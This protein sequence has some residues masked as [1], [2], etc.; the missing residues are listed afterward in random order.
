MRS[1]HIF[2]RH[3]KVNFLTKFLTMT[4][5]YKLN[6]QDKKNP[7]LESLLL[8]G[9]LPVILMFFSGTARAS[10]LVAHDFQIQLL[11]SESRITVKD[12][13]TVPDTLRGK[14]IQFILHGDL[15][16]SS[17]S[18]HLKTVALSEPFR[19]AAKDYEV[20][21]KQY[22]IKL[23]EGR[24]HFDLQYQGRIYHPIAQPGEEYER[25]MS[26][27]PGLISTDGVFLAKSTLWYPVMD[28]AFVR[29]S[30]KVT[31]PAKWSAV[32]Q[33]QRISQQLQQNQQQNQKNVITWQEKHPQDDIYLVANQYNEYSQAAGDVQAMVFLREPDAALAQK[34]LDA[35][36]QYITMYNRLIGEYPYRKFA[37]VE[38]FWDT[39]YG[40]PSFTLLGPKVIR[41]PFILH[42]SYPHEILH[43]WWG[44]GVYVDYQS[45]NWAEG[46]TAY[47]ADHLIKE[48]RGQ[49]AEYRRGALQKYTDFVTSERNF[50]LTEFRSRHNASTAAVG[51]GKTMMLFHMLRQQLGDGEFVR[52]LR[53][54][55]Q[56]QKF[57]LATF[58]DVQ[59]AF[60]QTTKQ[61][62]S[63]E[64]NQWV[65]R[66]GAPLLRIKSVNSKPVSGKYKI[67]LELEQQQPG[68][69]YK[70][71]VPIAVH[72]QG[73]SQAYQ[74]VLLMKD[75]QQAFQ[76]NVD[77]KPL[78][79]DVDPEFD[80]FRRLHIQEI[81]AALTQG[82][83]AEK[84]LILLPSAA[85]A[86]R[87][88]AY[89]QMAK[90]WQKSQEGQWQIKYDNEIDK[91]PNDS[92]IWLLGWE[93]KFRTALQNVLTKRGVAFAPG[94]ITINGE[95]FIR[96]KHSILLTARH[97][98]NEHQTLVWL[99][100][101][102]SAAVPGLTRKLPHYS[103]YSY[104]AF[105]GSE[106]T[107]IAKG[108]WDIRDSPMT[109][110]FA[111]DDKQLPEEITSSLAE[112]QALA[113]LPPVFSRER[114][115]KDIEFMASE[116]MAGRE[117]GSKELDTVAG[118]IAREFREAGLKPGGDKGE[119]YMQRWQH[120][121]GGKKGKLALKNIIGIIPGKD[122]AYAK[123]SVIISAHYDHLGKGWPDVHKG[124][125]GK[126]HHGA[127]D[128]ASGVAVMLELARQIAPQWEPK[129]AIV[130]IA[131]TGEEAQ[132]VGSKYYVK[133]AVR[134]PAK[135]AIGVINLD[136]VGRL[137][138]NPLTV[139]G[140]GSAR[141]WVH[142]FRG[143][144]FV[145][146][147]KINS[148]NNDFGFSD[149]K[150]FLEVGVPGVQL[151]GSVHQD[152]HRPSDTGDKIDADGLI[153]VATVLKEAVEY[154]ANR[155]EPMNVTIEGSTSN[156]QQKP[157]KPSPG[158]KVSLGTVPDFQYQGEGV[159]I[160]GTVDGS[161]AQ[162][163]GLQEGDI[164]T[165]IGNTAIGN[166]GDFARELRAMK[167][168][169]ETTVQ[170]TRDGKTKS[171][172]VI[173]EAR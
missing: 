102:N 50:P 140:V 80:V 153:K 137:G 19:S 32:S 8:L 168:G 118:Y 122:P 70:L 73:Y 26:E 61:S 3:K 45:G 126:V 135:K 84:I 104:L 133:N 131:F 22:R 38:N 142:I 162:K 161:P 58:A 41:F 145:T 160:T 60:E 120:D 103:K 68:K 14:T 43:N 69:A 92:T 67:N 94:K 2:K 28:D 147:I 108:Q 42:S 154:L 152:Y 165:R 134:Y 112:R 37:L 51:Y 156:K 83:G 47:L 113:Q 141:E 12:T 13:I 56:Q 59:T 150:S 93:N 119:S 170:Y 10:D 30:M 65:T 163:A 82:F 76:I 49:G 44:N 138:K 106:P 114:M 17:S 136:T 5:K 62:M 89:E 46:L 6:S 164:L 54:L 86:I 159:R 40:M 155:E 79:I 35:T 143:V 87:K 110:W 90:S 129:R 15:V 24:N 144:G 169:D 117:L 18:Q 27:T 109:H 48:Q 71:N 66:T 151:F 20:P 63:T 25:S 99:A 116:K 125:E 39:G 157:S 36:H 7:A 111:Y 121:F 11:P 128:N 1:L 21:V 167:P 29:F 23:G 33:G 148:V 146:G 75:K 78:R 124:D 123:Q 74:T 4:K 98:D 88:N 55:Y 132:R 97:P 85:P 172:N 81:P 127:D 57:K 139:F 31:V 158:R 77:G 34:Y 101:D 72:M 53:R 166:L 91:L 100:A 173:V 105:Q 130:F 64:F 107:N 115:M 96:Q 149:Q 95:Q 16:V 171:V 52:S 9:L